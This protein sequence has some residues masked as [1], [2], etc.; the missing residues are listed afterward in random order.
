MPWDII[1]HHDIRWG[2]MSCHERPSDSACKTHWSTMHKM[3][4]DERTPWDTTRYHKAQLHATR[5]HMGHHIM[6]LYITASIQHHEAPAIRH[7]ETP[8]DIT[9]DHKTTFGTT[10]HPV[11]CL[12]Q[13]K[14]HMKKKLWEGEPKNVNPVWVQKAYRPTRAC[15]LLRLLQRRIGPPMEICANSGLFLARYNVSAPMQG[16][17]E[18][19]AI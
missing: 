6:Q 2:I 3:P 8:W 4:W 13:C 16:A 14:V 1:R 11:Q 7:H 15:K 19:E 5:H 17:Y 10:S 12:H 18:K 9:R